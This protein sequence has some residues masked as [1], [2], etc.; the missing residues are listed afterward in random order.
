MKA[1]KQLLLLRNDFISIKIS[2][3]IQG[4]Q[5][6]LKIQI[7]LIIFLLLCK[8]LQIFWS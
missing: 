4:L 1:S 5:I 6:K 7:L 2:Q 3:P 8:V